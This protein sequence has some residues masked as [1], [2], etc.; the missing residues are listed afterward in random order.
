MKH[1]LSFLSLACITILLLTNCSQNNEKPEIEVRESI[2]EQI[3]FSPEFQNKVVEEYK[4]EELL[5]SQDSINIL[6]HKATNGKIGYIN[7]AGEWIIKPKYNKARAFVNGIAPIKIYDKWIFTIRGNY[8]FIKP[9][10]LT[11]GL[12][13]KLNPG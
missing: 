10:Y 7:L 1:N 9:C 8:S 2:K 13:P 3:T 12:R 4:K 5:N 6:P 11:A